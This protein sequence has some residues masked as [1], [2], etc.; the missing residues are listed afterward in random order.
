MTDVDVDNAEVERIVNEK[1]N[2]LDVKITRRTND[3]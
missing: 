3:D 1:L 2:N